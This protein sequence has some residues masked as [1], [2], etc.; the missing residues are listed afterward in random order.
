ML[1]LRCGDD[2]LHKLEAAG[3][4]GRRV[5]WS[6]PLCEGP[7]P[8]ADR[9]V[10]RPM[11]AAWLQA[12]FGIQTGT[13]LDDLVHADRQLDAA[14]D[15]DEVVLWFEADLFDQAILAWLLTRLAPARERLRLVTLHAYPG[16]ARFIGLGQLNPAQLAA[17]FATRQPV[18]DAMVSEAA[19]AWAAW[20]APTPGPLAEIARRPPGALPYLP[21]AVQRLLEELP[22]LPTGLGRT[23]RQGLM[24]I[25]DGATSLHE[26]FSRAQ[27]HEERP[28]AGDTMYYATMHPLAGGPSPLLQVDGWS[29]VG[30]ARLNPRVALTALATDVLDG[31]VDWWALSGATRWVGGTELGAGR[32]DWRWDKANG[33]VLR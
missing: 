32:P 13:T 15:E 8:S 28:W 11:R 26:S 31:T 23:E 30:D 27:E 7:V 12:H 19:A 29:Q 17:L 4:P 18:T 21:A 16:V 5:S 24:A 3:L 6:D 2:I 25:R 10:L 20:T 1:H 14:L 33:V 22:G 9:A